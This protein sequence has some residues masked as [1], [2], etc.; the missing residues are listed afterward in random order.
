MTWVFWSPCFHLPRVQITD[1][2]H[3]ALLSAGSFWCGVFHCPGCWGSWLGHPWLVHRET[4]QLWHRMILGLFPVPSRASFPG[5]HLSWMLPT[6]G[7]FPLLSWGC[8]V[9]CARLPVA[10][11][12]RCIE[13]S[14]FSPA[15]PS[16]SLFS[17][18][19]ATIW[20]HTHNQTVVS[21]SLNPS[22]SPR[23]HRLSLRSQLQSSAGLLHESPAPSSEL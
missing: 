19:R 13:D 11:L 2:G 23:F 1:V 17:V 16:L 12:F 7:L 5:L 18:L 8:S 20:G 14:D 22:P 4:L 6:S 15:V 10:S 9:L 3:Q 21:L